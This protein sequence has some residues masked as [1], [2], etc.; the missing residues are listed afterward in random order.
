M[1]NVGSMRATFP[2]RR[3][4]GVGLSLS[5]AAILAMTVVAPVSAAT[6][7]A[8][9]QAKVGSAGANGTATIQAY[10]TGSGS[11]ALK[12]AKLRAATY[13]PVTLSKGTCGSV[14]STLITFPA[15]R[16]T[17]SGTAG[18]TSSLT[19]LQVR[20]I[21]T[22][23]F[24][25]GKVAIR[26]GSRSTGGVK[27]GVFT[28]LY[29]PIG[30]VVPSGWPAPFQAALAS[31]PYG[32]R[33]LVSSD[34]ATELAA[35]RALI[36]QGIKVLV[37]TA[38]DSAA[39]AGAA[40]EARVAGVKVIANDRLILGTAA[41][42]SLVTFDNLAVGAA[43]GQYL[44]DK[45]GTTRGSNLYLYAGN[46]VDTNSFVFLEGAWEK[47]QPKIADGTFVIRNSSVATGFQG[48]PTLTHDQ[49]A[50]VIA[51]VTTNWD[52]NT[53][54][55]LAAGNLAAVPAAAKGTN[56]VL[57]PNDLTSL[58]IAS[59]FAADAA[60]TK[61]WL[62]GQ[63]ADK[64]SIQAIIDGRQGMTVFKDPR[65]RAKGV[66]A[67]ATAFLQG[68]TPVA[69]TTVNNGVIDIPSKLLP[70]VTVTRDNVQAALID[71]GYYK[72]SDF[73]GSWPGKR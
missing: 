25:T 50:Q 31:N 23:T 26:V 65:A 1:S 66:L 13:L 8:S 24:G 27:C 21:K 36:R 43:M 61:T 64:A 19:A 53:A 20:Q 15:I 42:D 57:A 7:G 12:L 14:G 41:V 47:L 33:L 67:A 3:R 69:T 28:V 17:R 44:V 49:L 4:L 54:R 46:A 73:T 30:I 2:G 10:T 58:A 51:Q 48:S 35:V 5:L 68:G 71:T 56:F 22:A 72:A 70:G 16:T 18:R 38:Q 62:T 45:A 9:W 63:D 59:A 39:A 11:L 40:D 52:Y 29:A 55:I 6:V 60:V 37:L 34:V 32:A